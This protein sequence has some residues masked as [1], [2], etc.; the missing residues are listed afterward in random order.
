M[1]VCFQQIAS[2]SAN[3][4]DVWISITFHSKICAIS[5]WMC[6]EVMV[7]GESILQKRWIDKVQSHSRAHVGTEI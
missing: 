4:F 6:L 5:L 7:G 3:F 1:C 2:K